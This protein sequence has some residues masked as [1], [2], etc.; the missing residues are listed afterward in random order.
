MPRDAADRERR[1]AYLRADPIAALGRAREG[2]AI[3]VEILAGN[4][5][6]APPSLQPRI[7]SIFALHLDVSKIP[8]S[9]LPE[10]DAPYSSPAVDCA[11]YALMGIRNMMSPPRSRRFVAPII[12]IWPSVFQWMVFFD[13]NADRINIDDRNDVLPTVSH[14]LFDLTVGDKGSLRKMV[15][16]TPQIMTLVA[17]IWMKENQMDSPSGCAPSAALEG[18]LQDADEDR[19]EEFIQA[20]GKSVK[21]IAELALSRLRCSIEAQDMSVLA[22]T[23][24][25]NLMT[26]FTGDEHYDLRRAILRK[27]CISLF[28]RA[29]LRLSTLKIDDDN[30]SCILSLTFI[31]LQNLM[32]AD[33]GIPWVQQAVR[34]GLLDLLYSVCTKLHKF[35]AQTRD[36]II[37]FISDI[38]P[39]YTVYPSVLLPVCFSM[40][41]LNT[42]GHQRTINSSPLKKSWCKLHTLTL[43]RLMVK[44]KVDR[45]PVVEFCYHCGKEA[46]RTEL[47]RCAGCRATLYCSKDCQVVSWKTKHKTECEL[48]ERGRQASAEDFLSKEDRMFH[49]QLCVSDVRRI[50][51]V[52]RQRAAEEF[53][54][55]PL[56]E[57]GVR[58]DYTHVPQAYSLFRAKDRDISREATLTDSRVSELLIDGLVD[59]ARLAD[60][61]ST[62]VESVTSVGEYETKLFGVLMK[63]SL[64]GPAA[65]STMCDEPSSRGDELQ[66]GSGEDESAVLRHVPARQEPLSDILARM[67]PFLLT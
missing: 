21:R 59:E 12:K 65:S 5:E 6:E 1:L 34:D 43:S 10:N 8:R 26:C 17:S 47:K 33:H 58:V 40:S 38:L 48:R 60:G 52:L 23:T 15:N 22:V 41:K 64:W 11:F 25:I 35:T 62:L 30:V 29:A 50:V 28:I 14:L 2:Y 49:Q 66:L 7:F 63:P 16:D 51:D 27:G 45:S 37:L 13:S 32:E 53:P 4:P 56:A 36:D 3:A 24:Q 9:P 20:T 19:I 54:D 18:I 67:Y 44:L 57:L 42:P 31:H 39:R 46:P 55:T 61:R